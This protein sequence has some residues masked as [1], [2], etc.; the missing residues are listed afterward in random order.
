[1]PDM[2]RAR[3]FE[4]R[5]QRGLVN[6]LILLLATAAPLTVLADEASD[7]LNQMSTAVRS[8]DYQGSFTYEHAGR[9]D[10]LR[11]FH[12]GSSGR[13][14]ERLVAL[15]GPRSELVRDGAEV[16]CTQADGTTTVYSTSNGRGLLPLVP[17]TDSSAL[18]EH[19]DIKRIGDDRVAGYRADVIDV[20]PRDR[21]RYGYRLWLERD[22]RLLL[23]SIVTDAERRP[24]EQVM[25]VS[26]DIGTPPAEADLA[27]QNRGAT[28]ATVA[29][30]ATELVVRGSPH[31]QVA[32]PP[33]GFVFISARRPRQGPAQAEHLVYSDGL[34]TVSVYIEPRGDA[35]AGY[36]TLAGR[37]TINVFSQVQD[38]WRI[39][40]LGDVPIA[41]VRAMGES[42]RPVAD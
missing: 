35:A 12:A 25:F 29:A 1:M 30:P 26:L 36:D 10:T 37:G 34:A 28:T 11:V 19:Y 2:P 23:R 3:P 31:W 27:P 8:L 13:E 4:R 18:G 9:V 41:T 24:L 20:V 32:T 6:L 39:T 14:R 7:I 16:T 17:T 40:V 33:A 38:E 5:F 42:V 21:F 22:T 15:N